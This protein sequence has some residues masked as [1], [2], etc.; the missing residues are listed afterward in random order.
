MKKI[1]L[2]IITGLVV[3]TSAVAQFH[4][5]STAYI[6]PN[7]ED[8]KTVI[9][10]E[11]PVMESMTIVVK[12]LTGKTVMSFVPEIPGEECTEI[13][14]DVNDLKRGIYICQITGADGKVKTLK[15]QKT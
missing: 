15:F 4:P 9:M 13:Q 10:F 7:A 11:E 5:I 8:N 2:A 14:L 3:S 12:D 1:L 6:S